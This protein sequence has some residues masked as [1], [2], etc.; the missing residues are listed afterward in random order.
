MPEP[1]PAGP[2]FG[3]QRYWIVM[4]GWGGTFAEAAAALRGLNAFEVHWADGFLHVPRRQGL[5][6][7]R[8]LAEPDPDPALEALQKLIVS[9]L[10]EARPAADGAPPPEATVR[11]RDAQ[12]AADFPEWELPFAPAA[13]G[14]RAAALRAEAAA[15]LA[16]L[17]QRLEQVEREL[18]PAADGRQ[19][20]ETEAREI[21]RRGPAGAE[22]LR[23][24]ETVREQQET[25]GDLDSVASAALYT[26][27]LRAEAAAAGRAAEYGRDY[28][29]AFVNYHESLR[30]LAAVGP[31]ALLIADLPLGA[32]PSFEQD[33]RALAAAGVT[34]A[35]F[36]DHHPATEEQRALLARL[37]AEGLIGFF[38]LSGPASGAELD[39]ARM[40]CGADLVYE[41]AIAGRPWDVPGARTLRR[42]AHGEDFVTD[43]TELGRLLTDAIKGGGNKV[44]IAAL[45]ADSIPGDDALERLRT[46]GWDR[47]AAE[48]EAALQTAEEQLLRHACRIVL[49]RPAGAPAVTG[50]RMAGAGS[51]APL[52]AAAGGDGATVCI[53]AA[54]APQPAPGEARLGTA[55]AVEFYSRRCAD[56]DYLFYCYGSSLLVSRRLN[57]ADLTLNLGALMA[58]LGAATDGG[59]AGAAVCRPEANP[60]YP[61]R[62]LGAVGPNNFRR[63]ADYLA[64]RLR[65]L[66]FEVRAVQ[67]ASAAS[68]ARLHEGGRQL[69]LILAVAIVV[70]AL[71]ALLSP[72]YRPAEIRRSNERFFPQIEAAAPAAA[73]EEPD[74]PEDVL[75]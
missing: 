13:R 43:R 3:A 10:L 24:L 51:D 6:L 2:E 42:A 69:G 31:A 46:R 21:V 32:L 39:P 66:G 35:R 37:Q 15:A 14:R 29:Y 22:L 74:R 59:H 56:A 57:Q 70:G 34:L 68:A 50:G 75:E 23:L 48:R 60:A 71:L 30:A 18:A 9:R 20:P 52:P 45:L 53:L 33:V 25:G 72:R 49:R 58:Q 5:L 64:W 47:W 67:D 8:L 27:R 26:W 1:G 36:E 38:A 12:L 16:P 61:R 40:K 55:A 65:G 17:W 41:N 44:E 62:L 11:W 54:L 7:R 63:F 28:R 19:P 73:P 4:H